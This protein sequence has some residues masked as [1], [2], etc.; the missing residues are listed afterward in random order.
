MKTLFASDTICA[1]GVATGRD[2]LVLNQDGSVLGV[3]IT[4]SE[5]LLKS[6][7]SSFYLKIKEI[8]E[9]S[10]PT[11]LLLNGQVTRCARESGENYRK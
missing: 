10:T 6:S 4:R 5:V 1:Q 2:D 7:I 3:A 11:L 8:S 9:D